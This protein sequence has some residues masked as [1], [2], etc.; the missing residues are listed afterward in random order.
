MAPDQIEATLQRLADGF[1]SWPNAPILHWPDEAGLAYEN[2]WF[3]SEDGVPLEGWFIPRPG[4]DRIV[5]ANHPRWFN[6]AGLPS[7]LE[8]WRSFGGATG[9]DFEVDFVPDYRILHDA[10]YNVLAYDMRNF[11]HSGRANGGI[12]SV[13]RYESRDV[14]GSLSYVR[15]RDDTRHMTI[16]LFSRCAGA[17]ATMF[18]MERR[19]AVFDGVRCMVAP[20]PLSSGVALERALERLGI[21]LTYMAD[22]NTRIRLQTS[23][24]ID[25]FSPVHWA[26][27]VRIPTFLYQ[28]RDDLYTRPSDI[29]AMFDNIPAADKALHW[30]EGTTRRWDGYTYFQREPR[31][32]LDWF[33]RFMA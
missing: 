8:P 5:I 16:G 31:R 2:V 23:F 15:N 20:Q 28:V 33:A 7:H 12:F 1:R 27:S 9:N 10:G 17:N 3:P 6:R 26:K 4:S 14:V 11:G 32:M 30:I 13:G 29:Q 18:A 24:S 19:P 22:L 25:Q 21:P